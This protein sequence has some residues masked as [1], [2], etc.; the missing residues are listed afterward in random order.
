M[1][2]DTFTSK[3]SYGH[4]A[5]NRTAR[6][7]QMFFTFLV[8]CIAIVGLFATPNANANMYSALGCVG[9]HG[10]NGEGGPAAPKLNDKSADYIVEQLKAYQDGTRVNATMNAMAPMT[11][12]HE[13]AIAKFLT[14]AK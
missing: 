12:G 3:K 5:Y 6:S 2:F 4:V 14:G 13:E 8:I 7:T 11:K 10:A 9:C 1:K